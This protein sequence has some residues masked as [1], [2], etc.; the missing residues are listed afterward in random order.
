MSASY[1]QMVGSPSTSP[2]HSAPSRHTSSERRKK[3][4]E[5][6]IDET[7][8]G[9]DLLRR[10]RDDRDESAFRALYREHTPRL[11]RFVHRLLG[12]VDGTDVEEAV[13]ETWVRAVE[14]LDAFDGRSSLMTWLHG[15]ALNVTRE[16]HRRRSREVG[17]TWC[18]GTTRPT[19]IEQGI[20]LE[21]ALALLPEKRRLVLVLHDLEGFRHREIAQRLGIS[22]GTSKSQ[23]HDARRQMARLLKGNDS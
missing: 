23:L 8:R 22:V 17:V 14:R 19:D 21:R 4:E 2:N 10:V 13:Q 1:R 11:A 20:D 7:E 18:Y 16:R 9:D 12:A 5:G 6:G 3:I 15:I